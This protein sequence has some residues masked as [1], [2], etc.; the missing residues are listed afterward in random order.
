MLTMLTLNDNP[1]QLSWISGHDVHKVRV[2]PLKIVHYQELL[3]GIADMGCMRIE[4]T[5]EAGF[6]EQ[7]SM[8]SS[9]KR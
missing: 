3:A 1:G 5:P 7:G 2:R 6:M 9:S 8:S 4:S